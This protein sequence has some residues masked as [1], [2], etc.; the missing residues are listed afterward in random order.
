MAAGSRHHSREVLR[1]AAGGA[2]VREF[3]GFKEKEAEKGHRDGV[4]CVAFSPDGK[5]IASGSSDNAIKLWNAA[6]GVV[7]RELIN[8]KLKAKGAVAAAPPQAHP[9]W[10]Q[11]LAFVANGARLVSAGPGQ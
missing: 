8:P 5:M 6:T 11:G 1:D 3:K 10:I 9:G 4:F 2:L 7:I